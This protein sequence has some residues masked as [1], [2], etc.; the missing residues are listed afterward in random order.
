VGVATIGIFLDASPGSRSK[1]FR[2]AYIE[3]EIGLIS[4][5]ALAFY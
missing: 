3:K 5:E 1:E 4:N 2:P